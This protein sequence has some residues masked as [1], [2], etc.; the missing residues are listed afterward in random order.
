MDFILYLIFAIICFAYF[1][2]RAKGKVYVGLILFWLFA[3]P[4]LYKH[5]LRIPVLNFDLNATRALFIGI[6]ALVSLS[7]ISKG[8]TKIRIRIKIF[9]LWMI[10]LIFSV[11]LAETINFSAIG[12]QKFIS[13]ISYVLTFGMAYFVLKENINSEHD[14]NILRKAFLIFG[15]TSSLV[16]FAQFMIFPDFLRIGV[17]RNAFGE[18]TRANG[19]LPNEFDQAFFL[20]IALVLNWHIA[21]RKKMPYFL[22]TVFG[23]AVFFTMH[24]IS[25]FVYTISVIALFLANILADRRKAK[26]VVPI[27]LALVILLI[28]AIAIPWES[29][30]ANSEFLDSFLKQRIAVDTWSIRVEY[31]K[32]AIKVGQLFPMGLG[33]Y[34]PNYEQI[35]Y[36]AGMSL[37]RDFT[38]FELVPYIV[39]NSFLSSLVKYGWLGM[40]SLTLFLL[41][42][43]LYYLK[44][45]KVFSQGM[46]APLII[47]GAYIL[48]SITQDFS[49][50]PELQ[51]LLAFSIALAIYASQ[52]RRM[53]NDKRPTQKNA[54]PASVPAV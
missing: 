48:F 6:I 3:M 12:L 11:L 1:V 22:V 19:L 15:L 4:F 43:T 49:F 26:I 9:E 53:L 39:H 32:L 16:A 35:V 40:T 23:V 31:Y 8:K 25:W 20:I 37:N 28:V 14:I 42:A 21:K 7:F 47:I 38:T 44:M 10:T 51:S 36:A 50:A 52:E 27:M 17:A 18:Y 13:D 45:Y 54:K 46:A 2:A 30:I 29:I 41:A 33:M 24:R 5:P 34:G